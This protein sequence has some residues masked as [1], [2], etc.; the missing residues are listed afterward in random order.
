M[1]RSNIASRLGERRQRF[2]GP[3]SPNPWTNPVF[4]GPPNR[5]PIDGNLHRRGVQERRQMRAAINTWEDE[6]GSIAHRSRNV[7][8]DTLG[9]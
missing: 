6:G 8:S 1:R 4:V 2:W 3:S 9:A 7:A 5:R